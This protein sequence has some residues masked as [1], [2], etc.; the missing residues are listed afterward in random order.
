MS[1][2]TPPPHWRVGH[3]VPL[4]LYRNEVFIGSV[5]SKAAA[6]ELVEAANNA[7]RFATALAELTGRAAEQA[8]RAENAEAQLTAL[9]EAVAWLT[10]KDGVY[11]RE[12]DDIEV[13]WHDFSDDSGMG[14]EHDNTPE[15]VAR[16]LLEAHA[17]WKEAQARLEK[18]RITV[19]GEP[20]DD[21]QG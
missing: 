18:N 11:P 12:L 14:H 4:T 6:E 2:D 9:K 8:L 13:H 20:A 16:A 5:V 15:D 17:A 1:S 3:K 19:D 10:G 21:E 7:S